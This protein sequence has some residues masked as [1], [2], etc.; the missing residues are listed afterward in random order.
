MPSGNSAAAMLLTR[1]SRL[2][3]ETFFM[4]QSRRQL[5][6]TASHGAEAP[7]GHCF[8]LLAVAEYVYPGTELVVVTKEEQDW[9]EL[10]RQIPQH[11]AVLVKTPS[12]VETLNEIAPFAASY[13]FPEEGTAYYVC[14][15]GAC[16]APVFEWE[17]C[18]ELLTR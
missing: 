10:L 12:S 2:T 3:G 9:P 4:E 11:A 16:Q 14:K 18:M 6:F 13:P 17:A 5:E 1:L 7:M 15:D 8:G